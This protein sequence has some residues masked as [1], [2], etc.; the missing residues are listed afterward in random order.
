[1]LETISK[2]FRNARHLLAHKAE[3]TEQTI[4]QALLEIRLSLLEADVDYQVTN[5]FLERV[6]QTALGRI[7]ATSTK[8]KHGNTK[9]LSPSEHFV[10]ICFEEL[11]ALM[12]PEDTSIKLSKP[13]GTIMMV[14]LQGSGKTTTTA[15]LAAML[16]KKGHRPLL[17]A[18]DIYR[19]AAVQQLQTLGE[20]LGIPVHANPQLKP[21][22]LCQEA[23][24]KATELQ[25]DVVIFDTAGRLAIDRH[26]MEELERIQSLTSPD[27]VFLVVDA[28]IGQDAVQTTSEFNRRLPIDGIILTKLDGDARG[29][30]ALS[31]RE[32]IQKPIKFLGVGE[33]TSQL[34]DFR[35]EGLAS[36]ILGMGDVVSLA[37]DFEHLVDQEK[38]EKD[39][40]KMLKGQFA[41]TDF[42]EQIRLLRKMGPIKG[43]LEKLPGMSDLMAKGFSIN[44]RDFVKIESIVQSMT[45]K[46][47]LAP[48]L[49]LKEKTR[50]KRIAKGCGH[51]ENDVEQLLN[52]FQAM[53][54]FTKM[55]G[56]NPSLLGR[57]PL[58]KDLQS[59]SSM[60][61]A[62]PNTSGSFGIPS[63]FRPHMPLGSA[64][65]IRLPQSIEQSKKKKE[66]RKNE[67]EARRKNKKKK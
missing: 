18:A 51:T 63:S 1:M 40:A 42:V 9:R 30:A 56:Q 48:D 65:G 36:R 11:V 58:F 66:K 32:R 44:D 61:G 33:H 50:K 16:Q 31:I 12:G 46:E 23:L 26:L 45:P 37:K 28:M 62:L 21:E 5:S 55:L 19:P 41:L 43:L 27:N 15:K 24:Q 8:D 17:V 57:L 34:E 59:L 29:G 10:R 6:K 13:I 7:V 47:R 4:E 52:R 67:K 3:L 2:G 35:P 53:K 22:A 20:S 60:Q 64:T 14:G 54:G 25:K 49:I 39:A 38:A